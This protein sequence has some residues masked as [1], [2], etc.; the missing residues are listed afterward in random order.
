MFLILGFSYLFISIGI[1]ISSNTILINGFVEQENEDIL[2]QL[3][4][5]LKSLELRLDVLE[6]RAV[7]LGYNDNVY[8]YMQ[9][10]LKHLVNDYLLSSSFIDNALSFII[11]QDTNGDIVLSKA[12][13]HI[14]LK[15][16]ELDASISDFVRSR[17]FSGLQNVKTGIVSMEDYMVMISASPILTTEGN[18]PQMGLMICGRVLDPIEMNRLS[19]TT[20]VDLWI[21]RN[22]EEIANGNLT[23]LDYQ[24]FRPRYDTISAYK[25]ITDIDGAES[26]AIRVESDRE[27]FNQAVIMLA[28]F[29]GASVLTGLIIGLV[30]MI[31]TNRFILEKIIRL[32]GEVNSINPHALDERRVEISGDD[33]ISELSVDIDRM[34]EAL[35]EYQQLLKEKERM[36]TIGETAAMVGHDLR[37]PLQVIVM[38]GSRLGKIGN[39]LASLGVDDKSLKE[40]SL[41]DSKLRDQ[42]GYMNKIVSDLQDFA[43][44]IRLNM[45]YSDLKGMI[46]GVVESIQMPESIIVETELD[47]ELANVY[48]DVDYLRRVFNNLINNALQAMQEG[49][50]LSILG[51]V[52]GDT[53]HLIVEDT[54]SGIKEEDRSSIFTPLF[55]TKAKGTGLG[56]AVCRRVVTAHNGRIW[57]ETEIGVGTQFHIEL[58]IK[59]EPS[60]EVDMVP[61]AIVEAP[62][63]ELS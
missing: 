54:G 52:D 10:G 15:N 30:A 40:L 27:Y 60:E 14:E 11:F 53:A 62:E 61:E 4:I 63:V 1:I 16:V 5:G 42:T 59:P 36:A 2:K 29:V 9:S 21:M 6:H 48:A 34:I 22:S 28:Y 57:Y 50:K 24:V 47:D 35:G 44:N 56:L 23:S 12:F 32:S 49:G 19:E 13:D 58:P 39:K 38:I 8:M 41:I 17:S 33:E 55:T 26:I 7:E 31:I 25:A 37:N 43:R 51:S 3:D 46:L 45:D 20:S 18:G